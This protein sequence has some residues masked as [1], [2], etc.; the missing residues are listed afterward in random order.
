MRTKSDVNVN[1]QFQEIYTFSTH[2]STL[3]YN[4]YASLLFSQAFFELFLHI[5]RVCKS[6]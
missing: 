2:S 4:E 1:V 5:K 6:F 3:I